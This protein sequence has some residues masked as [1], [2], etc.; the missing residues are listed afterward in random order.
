MI[1]INLLPFRTARKK[2]NIRRQLSVGLL[3][4]FFVTL[5]L[6]YYNLVL[7]NKIS[8]LDSQIQDTKKQVE[9]Y[10][11]DAKKVDEIKKKL[12]NLEKKT[13]VINN[14]ELNR[15][16]PV[17]LLE[18]M[19]VA[20]V[21]KRMW[22]TRFSSKGDKIVIDGVALDNKTVADFMTRLEATGLFSSVNLNNLQRKKIGK[23]PNLKGYTI[24]CKRAPLKKAAPANK[25]K[26]K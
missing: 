9:T 5:A 14:L 8:T 11:R 2:E 7:N 6:V 18:T 3:L 19:T 17:R 23:M 25:A 22:F 4:I 26:K 15:E 10:R 21:P 12:A 13:N 20:I 16:W 1:R 24:T